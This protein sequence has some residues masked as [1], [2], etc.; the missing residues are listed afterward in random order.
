MLAGVAT[1]TAIFNIL[2]EIPFL[3]DAKFLGSM[4]AFS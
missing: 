2:D 3:Y 1:A 4:M